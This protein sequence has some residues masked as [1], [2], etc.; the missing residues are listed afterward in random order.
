MAAKK[1][2]G[3][4]VTEQVAKIEDLKPNQPVVVNIVQQRVAPTAPKPC[5]EVQLLKT[6]P[7]KKVVFQNLLDPTE[8]IPMNY[9]SGPG[10]LHLHLYPGKTYNLHQCVID[11]LHSR[12]QIGY[13]ERDKADGSG[14]EVVPDPAK[15]K[16]RFLLTDYVAGKVS[17]KIA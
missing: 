3:K 6:S 5:L 10:A 16:R 13:S 7:K 1:E 8:D 9:G 14:T 17:T 2:E 4:Q 15:T 11:H 12:K